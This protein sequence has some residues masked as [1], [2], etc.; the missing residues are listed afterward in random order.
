[1]S[2]KFNAIVINQSGENFTRELKEVSKSFLAKDDVLVKI[3]YS[4]LNFNIGNWIKRSRIWVLYF[5]T[6]NPPNS[7]EISISPI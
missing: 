1:M 6:V 5:C 4:D 7:I 3:E 2:D